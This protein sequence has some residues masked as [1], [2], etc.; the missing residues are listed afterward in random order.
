VLA[1]AALTFQTGPAAADT[2]TVLSVPWFGQVH[3]LDC[4]AASLQSM[5]AYV[6][7]SATQD[8]ILA[9]MGDDARAGR[10][11]NGALRWGNAYQGFVGSVNGSEYDLTGYGTF[12]P[13]VERVADQLGSGAVYQAGAGIAPSAVYSLVAGG[14]P[15]QTWVTYDWA[16]HA[17]HDYLTFDGSAWIPWAGGVEH[18]VVVIGVSDTSVYVSDPDGGKGLPGHNYPRQYW[19]SKST[20]ET[21]YAVYGQMAVAVGRVPDTP[22]ARA[23]GGEGSVSVSWNRPDSYGAPLTGFTVILQPA[24]TT[25]NLPPAARLT[26]FHGLSP[27]VSYTATVVASDLFGPSGSGAS[28]SASPAAAAPLAQSYLNWYDAASPGVAA[29]N[30]HLFTA[31]GAAAADGCATIAGIAVAPFQIA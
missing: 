28:D 18:S 5:L 22:V 12:W 30:L 26:T 13:V 8:Q 23:C 16:A 10:Y 21:A 25:V 4:E 20:F 17:R 14:R 11:V 19:I 2:T 9:A 7:I 29:D 24:G 1:A 27:G 6:G 31:A 15:V 3:A